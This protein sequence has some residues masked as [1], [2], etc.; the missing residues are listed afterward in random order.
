MIT[1]VYHPP[2][3]VLLLLPRYR[4][5]LIKPFISRAFS[6]IPSRFSFLDLFGLCVHNPSLH[7]SSGGHCLFAVLYSWICAVHLS[8]YHDQI[9]VLHYIGGAF[10][11]NDIANYI[12]G[13]AFVFCPTAAAA[14]PPLLRQTQALTYIHICRS[15]LKQ[16]TG[17]WQ[18]GQMH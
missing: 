8:Y 1:L 7:L 14:A 15:A 13:R 12:Y 11:V 6:P 10:T 3:F 18:M 4:S 9:D 2:P 5:H 17:T 16:I